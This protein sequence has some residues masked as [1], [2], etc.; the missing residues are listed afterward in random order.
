MDLSKLKVITGK[1]SVIRDY[2]SLLLPVI[3]LLAAI[4]IFIPGQLMNTSL[5]ARIE[6]ES[7]SKRAKRVSSYSK[8]AV[9]LEQWKLEQGYQSAYEADANKIAILARQSSQ[10]ELLS[11][12]IFPQPEDT[13]ALIFEEFGQEYRKRIEQLILNLN[14]MDC[15]TGAELE[16]SLQ[17]TGTTTISRTTTYDRSYA[18]PTN[19]VNETIRD[20][21][22]RAKARAASVYANPADFSGYSFWEEYEYGGMDE[23]IEDCWYWQIAYWIIEDVVETVKQCNEGSKSVFTSPVKRIMT[24]SFMPV[25]YK[26]KGL[27]KE[28]QP[29]Y[30]YSTEDGFTNMLSGRFSNDDIDVVHFTVSIVVSSKAVL[31]FMQELC[32]AKQHAFRGWAGDQQQRIFRHNQITILESSI[33]S[34]DREDSNHNLYR[35]GEDAVVVMDLICEYIFNKSGYE[36]V[37]PERIKKPV[38][39]TQF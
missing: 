25:Q 31:D 34:V 4:G 1:I 20:E 18:S 22:C 15:P 32:S 2:S 37:K 38:T 3:I 10:R 27:L 35:Y 5:K 28:D 17:L 7:I 36:A 29:R 23:S 16:R 39:S 9:P 14:G 21:L 8:E 26:L 12:K 30:I 19:V 11:Y 33:V 13:S 24:V 6:A